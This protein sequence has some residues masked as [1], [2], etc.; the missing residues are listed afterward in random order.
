MIEYL[1]TWPRWLVFVVGFVSGQL[2]L[3]LILGFFKV[4]VP[5]D[6]FYQVRKVSRDEVEE[7]GDPD[8]EGG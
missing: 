5:D 6:D 1:M 3:A 7:V 2:S 4:V 8:D